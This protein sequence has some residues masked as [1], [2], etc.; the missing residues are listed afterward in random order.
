[1]NCTLT[2]TKNRVRMNPSAAGSYPEANPNLGTDP[3]FR[4]DYAGTQTIVTSGG[5][6]D[7]GLFET[8][9]RD[10]RYLPFEGAGAIS[11]FAVKLSPSQSFDVGTLNDVVL[12]LRY[13]ARDGGS[14]L[15]KKAEIAPNPLPE[16]AR[17]FSARSEFSDE[18]QQFLTAPLVNNER[19]LSLPLTKDR[20]PFAAQGPGDLPAKKVAILVVGK[21]ILAN[22]NVS[23]TVAQGNN[24]SAL[25]T[26]DAP[27][28][29]GWLF[30]EL[31]LP[32]PLPAPQG[33]WPAG[34]WTLIAP[35]ALAPADL[36]DI[37]VA[38][39]Y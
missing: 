22:A 11:S 25:L 24:N 36:V 16:R 5:Q 18:W 10:E 6:N 30:G 29:G 8:N 1:M 14:E 17:L 37:L 4:Y 31:S 34:I 12:H 27:P 21:N 7:S 19:L 33:P 26:L 20:F 15:A 3:R 38:F 35:G 9:L 13:T 2:L 23:V 28:S 32:P 39:Y